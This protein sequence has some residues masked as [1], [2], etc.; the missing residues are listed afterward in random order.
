MVK[1]GNQPILM[2]AC[3]SLGGFYL[4]TLVA[5]DNFR[6]WVP[7]GQF[8]TEK[9]HSDLYVLAFH[10]LE[11]WT[12]HLWIPQTFLIDGSNIDSKAIE[13]CFDSIRIFRC[14]RHTTQTLK[15]KLCVLPYGVCSFC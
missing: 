12:N 1:Y 5:R 7:V 4:V 10:K 13:L 2:D 6:C 15:A 11:E 3:G 8:W 14:T 9:E